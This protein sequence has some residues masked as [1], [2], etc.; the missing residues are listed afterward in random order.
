MIH[1]SRASVIDFL[2]EDG[3][4]SD[5]YARVERQSLLT[6]TGMWVILIPHIGMWLLISLM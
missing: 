3:R 5:T 2:V 1:Y 6:W 4:F